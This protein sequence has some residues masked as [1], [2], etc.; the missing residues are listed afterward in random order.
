LKNDKK[1]SL[2]DL[3]HKHKALLMLPKKK[4]E[5]QQKEEVVEAEP[6]KTPI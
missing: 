6:P 5:V 1:K 2:P 4:E 3:I